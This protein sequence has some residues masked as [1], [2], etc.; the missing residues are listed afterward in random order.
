MQSYGNK[1]TQRAVRVWARAVQASGEWAALTV[2]DAPPARGSVVWRSWP[3][4]KWEEAALALKMPMSLDSCVRMR[5]LSRRGRSNWHIVWGNSGALGTPDAKPTPFVYVFVPGG[6]DRFVPLTELRGLAARP[7]SGP[8]NLGV[9]DSESDDESSGGRIFFL[10]GE[11]RKQ[12]DELFKTKP[13]LL[14]A[15]VAVLGLPAGSDAAAVLAA[16]QLSPL[17]APAMFASDDSADEP[18]PPSASSA[19]D[20]VARAAERA[21]RAAAEAKEAAEVAERMAVDLATRAGVTTLSPEADPAFA[22]A[23]SAAQLLSQKKVA[24]SFLPLPERIKVIKFIAAEQGFPMD[25]VVCANWNAASW[26]RAADGMGIAFRDNVWAP[27]AKL[28]GWHVAWAAKNSTT[29][30]CWVAA[31]T[32]LGP[33]FFTLAALHALVGQSPPVGLPSWQEVLDALQEA[34]RPVPALV[35]AVDADL[36]QLDQVD[37]WRRLFKSSSRR[38]A[39]PD[40]AAG[41]ARAAE[42]EAAP[43]ADV[44]HPGLSPVDMYLQL[45]LGFAFMK[46]GGAESKRIMR[47]VATAA[48]RPLGTANSGWDKAE[49]A[50]ASEELQLT[51]LPEGTNSCSLATLGRGVRAAWGAGRVYIYAPAP[52]DRFMQTTI[53]KAGFCDAALRP[54]GLPRGEPFSAWPRVV[55]ELAEAAASNPHLRAALR[56]DAVFPKDVLPTAEETG[57]PVDLAPPP[58]PKKPWEEDGSGSDDDMVPDLADDDGI[59]APVRAE[60]PLVTQF[61]PSGKQLT[62][63]NF[64]GRP[65]DE[66]YGREDVV[67]TRGDMKR[68][69]M[70]DPAKNWP[71]IPALAK[72]GIILSDVDFKVFQL[73][74]CAIFVRKL[75]DGRLDLRQAFGVGKKGKLNGRSK[76]WRYTSTW[77]ELPSD[78]VDD[79][80]ASD[81]QVIT[82]TR[83]VTLKRQR[84]D[85]RNF[86]K[87]FIRDWVEEK[88]RCAPVALSCACQRALSR[89]ALQ[90]V[91]HPPQGVRHVAAR[92]RA[93]AGLPDRLHDPQPE[94]CVPPRRRMRKLCAC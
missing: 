38:A 5:T 75:D 49:W 29:D 47:A 26:T 48:K 45:G 44:Q 78:V 83:R 10:W 31:P 76:Y 85:R 68:A 20:A 24:F 4:G 17:P 32:P 23:L 93:A 50:A 54:V 35:A 16:P 15:A 37:V 53:I 9:S 28:P 33:R 36:E 70:P 52:V 72:E 59:F 30:T 82:W 71:I 25:P 13:A 57:D 67:A 92:D 66:E 14:A 94:T 61:A 64:A 60:D 91:L 62:N 22:T 34:A 87:A 12:L 80:P 39:P 81:Y 40:E 55:D 42:D 89:V 90:V 2:V 41:R 21:A 46:L 88:K 86:E 43:A 3:A 7:G 77:W 8:N 58:M 63:V 51:W 73:H 1:Q 19:K 56:A 18:A 11:A 27:L 69:Y 74:S 79:M 6:V 65:F 84:G